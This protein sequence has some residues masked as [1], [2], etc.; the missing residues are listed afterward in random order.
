MTTR[1]TRARVG[2]TALAALGL[3]LS[4]ASPAMAANTYAFEGSDYA[5]TNPAWS[6]WFEVCD[7]EKD[8]N[9]VYAQFRDS[10]ENYIGG[11]DAKYW[12]SDGSA[13]GCRSGNLSGYVAKIQV[14][15]DDW[16]DDTCSGW[17]PVTH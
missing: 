11:F 1:R 4:A 12:D 5:A 17:K 6:N 14:C 16:G 10:Y 15:E 8:G 13:G 7:V 2:F 3:A 9:G